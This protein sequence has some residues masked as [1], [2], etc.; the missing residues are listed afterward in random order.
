MAKI[1]K[2]IKVTDVKVGDMI[3]RRDILRD[4]LEFFH[5]SSIRNTGTTYALNYADENGREV[6]YL[7]LQSTDSLHIIIEE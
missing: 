5:I 6:D 4:K 7:R 2:L 1:A 3:S